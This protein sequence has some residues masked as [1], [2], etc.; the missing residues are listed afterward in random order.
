MDQSGERRKGLFALLILAM[1][2][3]SGFAFLG[4]I[5]DS[6]G[7][8]S[9]EKDG[10]GYYWVDSKSP[11]P[12]VQYQW[13]NVKG[14]G[15]ELTLIAGSNDYESIPLTWDFPFYGIN[16]DTLY[17]G[18]RG[19]VWFEDY[20]S[21][22]SDYSSGIPNSNYP[23]PAIMVLWGV[24]YDTLSYGSTH[25]LT[26]QDNTGKWVAI[27]WNNNNYG[28]TFEVILWETG[29]IKMQYNDVKATSTSYDNGNYHSV[30]IEDQD[31]NE[32]VAYSQYLE[33]NLDNNLAVEFAWGSTDVDNFAMGNGGG[34]NDHIA[35]AEYGFYHFTMDVLDSE[36]APDLTEVR[37]Y[38]GQP[39]LNIFVKY[40]IAGGLGSWG[41]GGGGQYMIFDTNLSNIR[42]VGLD[43]GSGIE[44]NI[45]VKFLFS[46]PLNGN[47]SLTIWSRGRVALPGTEVIEDAFYLDSH[48]M[49]Y[50]EVMVYNSRGMVI[51]SESFTQ[52]SENITFTGVYLAYNSTRDIYPPNSSFYYKLVD[53]EFIEYLDLNA[54]GRNMS[55]NLLMPSLAIRKEFNIYLMYGDGSSFPAEKLIG[56]FPTFAFR[57][58]DSTPIAP[59]SVV[60]RADSF[61]DKERS[62]DNDE[63]IYV[64]WS[65]VKDTGSGVEKYRIWTT[66][67]PGAE[68]VP[69]VNEKTT[70]Y[71]WNGTYE[72]IF[73]IF[74]WAED[75]VGHAGDYIETSMKID[76]RV[77]FFTD[78]YPS[79][80][81]VPWVR[82]MNPEV[83]IQVKDNLSISDG[84][85][86]VRPST[87]EYSTSTSG[88]DNFEEWISAD[89][90][91]DENIKEV[92]TINVKLQP[93]FVEGTQNYIR[94][95]AKDY[96]GNGYSYSDIYNLKIDVT[97]VSFESFFPTPNVWHDVDIISAREVEVYLR[98]DIS[99]IRTSQIYYRISDRFDEKNQT[100]NWVTGVPQENGWEKVPSRD[101][102]RV[103]GNNLIHIHFDYDG[104][105][106][107]SQNFIQFMTRDEAGN[108]DYTPY[109]GF[110]D[111]MTRSQMYQINVN[112]QPVAKISSPVFWQE[113]EITELITFDASESYD[114]DVD[115][116]NLKF[117][118]YCHE[119]NKTL[120]YDMV[121]ENQRFP[122]SGNYNVTLYVADS[123]HRLD[124]STGI[125]KRSS[126]RVWIKI[127]VYRPPLPPIDTDGDGMWDEWEWDH[128][129]DPFLNDADE[130]ADYDGYKNIQ[131]FLGID[132]KPNYL[133]DTDPWDPTDKPRVDDIPAS[134]DIYTNEQPFEIWIFMAILLAAIII[135]AVIVLIGYLRVHRTEQ[136]E[137]TEEAEEEAM[138]ATP[139][140]D[141]PTMPAG[142]HMVDPSISTLPGPDQGP[143][144]QALPPA[145]EA[146]PMEQPVTGGE[147][148]QQ[149]EPAPMEGYQQPPAPE[150]AP[151]QENPMYDGQQ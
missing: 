66:Y 124:R 74:V 52:E 123:V 114:M 71:I 91:D 42:T 55:I 68:D 101:W 5:P 73:K 41:V 102:D 23:N 131:E 3:L 25:Y 83:S 86:G 147:M 30:G 96:A 128:L 63:I 9:E 112:T 125:D 106:E 12:K 138:L 143:E 99:G 132:G 134:A 150:A 127:Y 11:D 20:G 37:V 36:N 15:T 81:E 103:S 90:H 121:L 8:K 10:F 32:Y 28:L 7:A 98:D 65:S 92:D 40:T 78:F 117:E 61:K 130:D 136:Q 27:E 67:A 13:I 141:I 31:A 144:T 82:N 56:D 38:F 60:I 26:G 89:L 87:I 51:P 19:M 115:A 4:S 50:G 16:Y 17:V 79:Q 88:I 93:R 48:A 24:S 84:I 119:L 140:L 2:V 69:Y 22:P 109:P 142:M 54:S 49:L 110:G 135:A 43:N 35:F 39:S 77:P 146:A 33:P 145:M 46:I 59:A 129:L 64:T 72:G 1:L 139:Q 126:E 18:S 6:K 58:D 47:L 80:L 120:G 95:R 45:Y 104:F 137:M 62:V 133:D 14:V 111:V 118:W 151:V 76:K 85:S 94:Y 148:P 21:A 44:V 57:V 75:G 70:Q 100:Y 29:L 105:K 34:P 53:D 122:A 97:P 113:F 107:G 116:G 149:P 108:G